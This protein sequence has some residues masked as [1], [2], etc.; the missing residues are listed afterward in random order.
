MTAKQKSGQR[1]EKLFRNLKCMTAAAPHLAEDDQEILGL[2]SVAGQAVQN[3]TDTSRTPRMKK[4][5]FQLLYQW[6]VQNLEPCKVADIGGGKGLL[7]YLLIQKGWEAV[8]IDPFEQPLPEKYK[9]IALGSRVK[10]PAG[11]RIPYIQA[12]F[13]SEMAQAFDLLV[14]MHAHGCNV[15]IIDAAVEYGCGFIIFPCC[16]IDEPFYPPLGVHWLESLAA[17]AVKR[18][19][20]IYPFRLNFKGQNIGL[21]SAGRCRASPDIRKDG[22]KYATITP[23]HQV[24]A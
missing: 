14:G 3:V 18:G 8:V 12:E 17:Y 20:V 10:I 13:Q 6:M 23:N 22:Y 9:D 24:N 21:F 5:R 11:A 4:F 16:V 19:L 7:S 15:K 1:V 2:G